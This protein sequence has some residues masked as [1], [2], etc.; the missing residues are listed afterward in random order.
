MP[1]AAPWA[2]PTSQLS[3][4]LL[5]NPVTTPLGPRF[6]V[7]F[8]APT[9]GPPTSSLPPLATCTMPWTFRSVLRTP[10]RLARLHPFVS[11]L[12]NYA[13]TSRLSS[14]RISP[15]PRPFGAHTGDPTRTHCPFC[16]LSV[17]ASRV[18]AILSVLTSCTRGC[19]PASPW[20]FGNGALDRC[21]RAGPS[22]EPFGPFLSRSPW[23]SP[24]LLLLLLL[25][26]VAPSV[27][28]CP[29]AAVSCVPVLRRACL[30]QS[31]SES[32]RSSSPPWRLWKTWSRVASS[33]L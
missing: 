10:S 4:T 33:P 1:P 27:S 26:W 16:A 14:D 31:S 15:I 8:L 28:V 9:L 24:V 29:L 19:I 25:V 20:R 3:S 13:R 5:L 21:A 30:A 6:L 12:D 32:W 17:D 18:N 22:L 2:R 11:K 23:A 7:S